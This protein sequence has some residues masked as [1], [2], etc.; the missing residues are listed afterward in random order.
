VKPIHFL[1]V[2]LLA[3]LVILWQLFDPFIK[4]IS[5][6]L[7]LAIATNSIKQNIASKIKNNF[8]IS[9]IMSLLL[10]LL[11]FVP[12]MYFISTFVHYA[13]TLDQ[14]YLIQTFEQTKI[15]VSNISN[16][17]EFIKTQLQ[18][19]LN[20]IDIKSTASQI[21]SIGSYLGKNTASFLVDMVMI[22][23]FYS[24]FIHYGKELVSYVK[25]I[26]PL[27]KE[28][29]NDLFLEV[30]NVMGV[31]FYSI[32][33]TALLEGLLFGVFVSQFGYDGLLTGILY[34]FASLIPVV[35]GA[36]MWVPIALLEIFKNDISG[37]LYITIY[38][39]VVIS[40]IAD[41]IIKPMIISYINNQ[42]VKT[43]TKIN[44]VLI[45]FSILAGLST[46]GF[47]G[48]IIG[49]ATVTFFISILYIIK[50]HHLINI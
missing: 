8:F 9:L 19:V 30:S 2:V 25:D 6:A 39:I 45:F 16:D 26:L 23:I 32:L 36:L 38:S 40:I 41:T 44:E 10:G 5:V 34:G 24:F 33:A 31:V 11:F 50:K 35:G 22:L 18:E 47:W 42:V 37:A 15:F 49:P 1:S 17:Y 28:D 4:A 12:L 48:M 7:L 46:F 29:S 3:T 14:D 43:P 20:T 27:K 21:L 13:N